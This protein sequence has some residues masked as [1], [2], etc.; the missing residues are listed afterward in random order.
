MCGNFAHKLNK[1]KHISGRICTSFK[2]L[3]NT[4]FEKWF[5]QTVFERVNVAIS[6]LFTYR[7]LPTLLGDRHKEK[8]FY[9]NLV[10]M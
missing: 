2:G 9:A 4:G 1:Y 8:Y 5:V 6:P 7:L 3:F 10:V